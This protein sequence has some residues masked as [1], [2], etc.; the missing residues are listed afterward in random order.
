MRDPAVAAIVEKGNATDDT[1]EP[2]DAGATSVV[3]TYEEGPSPQDFFVPYLWSVVVSF[4]FHCYA[5]LFC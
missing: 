3:L 1:A 5:N 2:V 4:D